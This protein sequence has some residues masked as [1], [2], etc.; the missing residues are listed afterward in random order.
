VYYSPKHIFIQANNTF[1]LK[2]N[3]S[4]LYRYDAYNIN[5][6]DLLFTIYVTIQYPSNTFFKKWIEIEILSFLLNSKKNDLLYCH[7][8]QYDVDDD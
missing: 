5:I 4:N 8:I 2:Y 3:G 7:I 1:T 6:Y